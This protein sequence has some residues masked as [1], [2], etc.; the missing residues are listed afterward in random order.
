MSCRG[1]AFRRPYPILLFVSQQAVENRDPQRWASSFVIAAYGLYASFLRIRPPCISSFLNSLPE[2][3]FI[4]GQLKDLQRIPARIIEQFATY[5]PASPNHGAFT[6]RRVHRASG[7]NARS[8]AAFLLFGRSHAVHLLIPALLQGIIALG[9]P[10]A[11]I[12]RYHGLE[13]FR[14]LK[15]I[16]SQNRLPDHCG[17]G[18]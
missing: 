14:N 13:L 3:P 4:N 10:T 1:G 7:A 15:T 8:G 9:E 16:R 2:M 11:Q 12:G 6:A 17:L 5:R 18:R